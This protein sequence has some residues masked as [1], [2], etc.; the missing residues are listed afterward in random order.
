MQIASLIGFIFATFGGG[1][2]CDLIT[3]KLIHRNKGAFTPEQRLIS[4]IPGCF[5]G[6]VGCIIIAFACQNQLH[7]SVIAV[8]FG[9]GKSGS[10]FQHMSYLFHSTSHNLALRCLNVRLTST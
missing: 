8:G 7:W 9:L 4:I 1:Y 3:A 2:L 5:I 10:I 6:P